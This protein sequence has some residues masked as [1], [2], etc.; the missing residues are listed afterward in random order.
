MSWFEIA[1]AFP[2]L[3]Q[4]IENQLRVDYC[5]LAAMSQVVA[6][7]YV[8]LCV[9]CE[10]DAEPLEAVILEEFMGHQLVSDR[11]P[12]REESMALSPAVVLMGQEPAL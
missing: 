5:D 10:F 9:A 12:L 1:N 7:V 4:S 11:V 2:I 8:V 3:K 6:E